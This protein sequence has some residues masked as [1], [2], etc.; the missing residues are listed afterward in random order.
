ML[1]RLIRLRDA[2]E[3]VGM[4]RNRFKKEVKPFLIIIPIGKK[5]I[6]FDRLDLDAWV[7]HYKHR[8]GRPARERRNIAWDTKKCQDSSNDAA[9]GT[10]TKLS[11]ESGFQAALALVGLKKRKN[12]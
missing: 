12:T 10:S 4:D 8:N 7:D 6:A 5:G 2:P 1:P 3:Y 9:S 11:T